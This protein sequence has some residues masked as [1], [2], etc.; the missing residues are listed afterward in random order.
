[1]EIGT[2]VAIEKV[3][4]ELICTVSFG[5]SDDITAIIYGAA[6]QSEYPMI[7]DEVAVHRAGTQ[8]TIVTL[9]RPTPDDLNVGEVVI[10]SRDGDGNAEASV[11]CH[12]DGRVTINGGG[13]TLV[14]FKDLKAG[15]DQ[16]TDD[17]N[18]LITAYNSHIHV[19][20]ATV[21]A[22]PTPGDLSPVATSAKSSTASIDA[23]ESETVEAP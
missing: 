18:N 5:E 1:M 4:S 16:L 10:Y 3:E 2:I 20:T 19:T 9:Y 14:T 23:C 12:D 21:G 7:D 8:N 6:N 22:T 13:N 17:F 11:K 15:F